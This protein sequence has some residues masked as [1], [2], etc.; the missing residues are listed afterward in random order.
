MEISP[1]A[2]TVRE[3]GLTYLGPD[4]LGR[5]EG[6]L[7]E[8]LDQDVTGDVVEFGIALGGSAIVLARMASA[9]GRRFQGFDLFGM[10]PAPRS[11]KDDDTS[12]ARY[13]VIASGQS[14][15]LN[16]AVYYGY[17]SDLYEEVRASFERHGLPV[18]GEKVA[19]H[20][21]LFE[22]TVPGL[23]S[24]AIALA[25]VDC[26]WYDPVSFCLQRLADRVAPGGIVLLDDY[27]DYG[28]CRTAAQEFLAARPDYAFEAGPNA[29]LRRK[30]P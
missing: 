19:L 2:R 13:A 27:N 18:D 28:G 23:L 29:I 8:V 12:R 5:L 16:G 4:R 22:D 26:D 6:A 3:E 25:H 17:R 30:R 7:R 15:G 21:G 9:A 20:K 14:T 10:I 1:T 24:P 11:E